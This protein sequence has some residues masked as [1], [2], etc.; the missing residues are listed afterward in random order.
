MGIVFALVLFLD[1]GVGIVPTPINAVPN[2][3]SILV[4]IV[5]MGIILKE[6]QR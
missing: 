6:T 4:G 5:T 3:V 2:F 1:V